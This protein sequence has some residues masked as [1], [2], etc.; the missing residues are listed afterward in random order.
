M[1][2]KG[3]VAI[4]Y[5]ALL[6]LALVLPTGVVFADEPVRDDFDGGAFGAGAGWSD[7]WQTGGDVDMVNE[8]S[9]NVGSWHMRLK[10]GNGVAYRDVD[11]SALTE[12]EL[13]IWAKSESFEAG[14]YAILLLGPPGNLT[15][16]NRWVS[17]VAGVGEVT[18]DGEYHPLAIDLQGFDTSG[19]FR[20]Q[21]ESH[22][23]DASDLFYL[24][25]VVV[26][27]GLDSI[28]GSV[29]TTP[30][31]SSDVIVLDSGFSDWPGK[32]NISDPSG[33]AEKDRGDIGSF[34]WGDNP[35]DET[36]YWMLER[37]ANQT[38]LV[39]YSLHLDM[40]NDGD[41]QDA[42]DRIVQVKYRPQT[43][44][45]RVDVLVRQADNHQK[46]AQYKRNDWGDSKL[47]GGSRVEFG[48]PMDDLGFSF[49][50]AFRM[51]VESNWDDRAP[52]TGDVQWSPMPILGAVGMVALL[53][54]GGAGIWWF[55]LRR[56]E[57]REVP[58]A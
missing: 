5:M 26:A 20:I 30:S 41:F 18:A 27:D 31:T 52:D 29:T 40:N 56:Y 25:S 9:A 4:A 23:T 43:S 55:K 22:M 44:N 28:E 46:I 14:E 11:V 38:K 7:G 24:D 48:V 17:G 13:T 35:D 2:F 21:F 3:A 19:P 37:V 8:G 47:E 33:D 51:Y 10:S 36:I 45:S 50:S 53:L 57:G 34:Y 1:G 39:M 12:L 42:N 15:E 32:A 58:Q 54:V 16:V 49:G 6:M